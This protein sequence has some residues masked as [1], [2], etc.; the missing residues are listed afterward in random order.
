MHNPP[1]D[2]A[3]LEK[4]RLRGVSHQIAFFVAIAGGIVLGALA[5]HPGQTASAAIYGASLVAMFGGSALYHRVDWRSVTARTWARRFD[6]STI[7]L[8][9]AGTYT[10][11]AVLVL[12]HTL[13]IVVLAV[14]WGGAALGL[15]LNLAWIDSPRWLAVLAY[16]GV[17]WVAVVAVPQ[18]L[19]GAGVAVFVLVAVGGGLY[20]A[21]ALIYAM[22]RPRLRASVFGFHE[23][24]HLLVVAAAAVQY[25]GV[26][27]VVLR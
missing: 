24:F 9:I 1:V 13:A 26:S 22:R 14:V 8:F 4:P 11:F 25:V 17:G 27:L 20:T 16:L 5:E 15:V 12:R 19:H 23:A 18:L 21:G 10:P 2:P 7:F 6:H 3:G